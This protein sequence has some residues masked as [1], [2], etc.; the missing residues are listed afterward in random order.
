MIKPAVVV[1]FKGRVFLSYMK[2]V[3]HAGGML[4]GINPDNPSI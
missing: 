4:D 3:T 1:G 2:G